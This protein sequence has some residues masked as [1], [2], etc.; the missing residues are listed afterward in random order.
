MVIIKIS[1]GRINSINAAILIFSK[2]I[3]PLHK[4]RSSLNNFK[5]NF[6]VIYFFSLMIIDYL[7]HC[8]YM[9]NFSLCFT[10][11]GPLYIG[12]FFNLC[13]PNNYKVIV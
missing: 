6:F 10:I 9:V 1:F 7:I 12:S 8:I 11:H 2:K 3:N 13:D 5:E 4:Y